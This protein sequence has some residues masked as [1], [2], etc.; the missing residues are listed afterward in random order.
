MVFCI[1]TMYMYYVQCYIYMHI[2]CTT[3]YYIPHI[4]Y[5]IYIYIYNIYNIWYI[6]SN[7]VE[8]SMRPIAH[9][10]R[11]SIHV[12]H[13]YLHKISPSVTAAKYNGSTVT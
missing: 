6:V 1:C 10:Y 3:A 12:P 8:S 5:Y 7:S 9:C 4:I 11:F 13:R 2:L